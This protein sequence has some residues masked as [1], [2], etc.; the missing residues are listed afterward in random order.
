MS[1]NKSKIGEKDVSSH[2]ANQIKKEEENKWNS[3]LK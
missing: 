3:N 2:V 1:N